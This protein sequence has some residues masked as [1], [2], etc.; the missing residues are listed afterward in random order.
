V[1]LDQGYDDEAV[2][3][4]LE[5]WGYTAHMRRRGEER[6]AK[7]EIPGYQARRWV[8]ERTHA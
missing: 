3:E 4:T 5:D 1:C 2:R 6:Q 8:V 7:C